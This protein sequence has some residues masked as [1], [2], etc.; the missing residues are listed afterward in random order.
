MTS[1]AVFHA[2]VSYIVGS[3]ILPA[4]PV[5]VDAV[6]ALP[7]LVESRSVGRLALPLGSLDKL[8]QYLTGVNKIV[9]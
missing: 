3:H 1:S 7:F 5:Q 8:F 9:V 2:Y 4:L 6:Q